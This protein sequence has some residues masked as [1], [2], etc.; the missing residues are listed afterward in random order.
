MSNI[1]LL[2]IGIATFVALASLVWLLARQLLPLSRVIDAINVNIGRFVAWGLLAAVIISTGNAIVRKTLDTSSNSWLEAQWI[3]FGA[4]FL[5]CSPWTLIHNEH[6][7][8]DI[9]SSLLPQRL[10]SAID[11]VCHIFFLLP[12]ALV[13]VYTSW[14]FFVRS[15]LQNEQ[16]SNA[17][18][19]PVYPSKA[20]VLIGFAL[21]L[22]QAVSEIIKRTAVVQGLIDDP[23]AEASHLAAAEQEA[24]RL[25]QAIADEAAKRSA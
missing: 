10:R 12:T 20:L 2:A 6:I 22:M 25:R 14:P 9:V 24:E 23:L 3:L 7:R 19:L 17:G 5:I 4:V 8:I 15:L 21:L 16:S 11:Y 13:M 1:T 18:G